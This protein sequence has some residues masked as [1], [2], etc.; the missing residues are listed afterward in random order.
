MRLIILLVSLI[1]AFLAQID[2]DRDYSGG[3]LIVVQG[4]DP[5]FPCVFNGLFLTRLL[6]VEGVIENRGSLQN[7]D[8]R[9]YA[10]KKKLQVKEVCKD[11]NIIGVSWYNGFITRYAH[12]SAINV[13]EGQ[14]VTKGTIL[15]I[16]GSTGR[17]TGNHLHY[18][19]RHEGRPL[20]PK[21]FITAGEYVRSLEE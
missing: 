21:P 2:S 9:T 20:N 19:V 15:G 4:D 1:V 7:F 16:Q 6:D 5:C 17:S 11:G 8:A 10:F 18:E 13:K 3:K 14:R 12:L